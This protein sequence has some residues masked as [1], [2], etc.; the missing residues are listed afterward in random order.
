MTSFILYQ[1]LCIIPN[2]PVKSNWS[3]SPETLNVGKNRRV[4]VPCDI[5]MWQMTLKN[6][7]SLFLCCFK[8]CAS[9]QS[10]RGI[11]PWVTVRK[12]SIRVK[13]GDFLF[14]VTLKFD[15]WPCKTIGHLC[16]ATS[17]FVYYFKPSVNSNLSDSPETFNSGQNRRFFIPWPWNL[18]DDLAKN[19]AP[20]LCCFKLCASFHSHQWIQTGV[21]VQKPSIWVKT[22]N[23]FS[24]VTL[25]FD[26]W[27]SNTIGRLS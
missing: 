13:I 18:M 15:G 11:Q 1:A 21:K 27:P 12:H 24:R 20:F 26:G 25:K 9:L 2:P 3:Y 22:D 7:R 5:E 8:L 10:H 14:H 4:F 17:S 6:N 19:R 23:F 16:Y